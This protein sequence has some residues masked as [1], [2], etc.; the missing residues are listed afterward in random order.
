MRKWELE[1]LSKADLARRIR[2]FIRVH[3]DDLLK[4]FS[5]DGGNGLGHAIERHS[6]QSDLSLINRSEKERRAVSQFVEYH[7]LHTGK[8][9]NANSILRKA[10]FQSISKIV[11]WVSDPYAYMEKTIRFQFVEPIGYGFDREGKKKATNILTLHLRKSFEYNN[12]TGFSVITMY[13]DITHEKAYIVSGKRDVYCNGNIT[14]PIP[15]F[16]Y[17]CPVNLERE[18]EIIHEIIKQ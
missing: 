12:T 14:A 16:E 7:N 9:E 6:K 15:D 10:I 1:N 5:F 4:A 11:D 18:R 3:E 8:T 17:C 13:P 2:L